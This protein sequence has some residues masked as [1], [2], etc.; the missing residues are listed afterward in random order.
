MDGATVAIAI[1]A[2]SATAAAVSAIA[3]RQSVDRAHRPFVWPAISH[4]SEAGTRILRIRL[5]NDGAGSAFDV[6]WSFGTIIESGP[7]EY[8]ENRDQMAREASL[9]IR[10]IR[11]GES[12][13]PKSDGWLEK[14]AQLPPDDIGWIV[15]RWTDS[16]GTRWE[17]S[18]QGPATM[19]KRPRR[20]RHWRWQLWRR[21]ADW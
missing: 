14:A 18:D 12:V 4:A 21:R 19:R 15:V 10:A 13:P 20:L 11:P 9:A 17:A 16:G 5:H 7:L 1:A 8:G 2:V 6:R 3:S